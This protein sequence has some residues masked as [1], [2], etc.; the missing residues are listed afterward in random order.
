M[1]KET[2]KVIYRNGSKGLV[3]SRQCFCIGPQ[4]GQ[5]VCPCRMRDVQIQSGRYVEVVD[6]GPA[7]LNSTHGLTDDPMDQ[8]KSHRLRMDDL[9]N[10]FNDDPYNY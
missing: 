3:R 4:N 6:R 10:H 2:A 7:P 1:D 9:D 5:P 8:A